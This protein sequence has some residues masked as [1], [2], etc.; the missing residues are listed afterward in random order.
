MGVMKDNPELIDSAMTQLLTLYEDGQIRP[1]VDSTWAFEDVSK[2]NYI[3]TV[4][5]YTAWVYRY[6]CTCTSP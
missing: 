4:E 6:T 2:Y 3:Y 1:R 5:R